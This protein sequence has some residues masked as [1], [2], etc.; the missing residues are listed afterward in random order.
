M[1]HRSNERLGRAGEELEQ[2]PTGGGA[3]EE[4]KA[5][6]AAGYEVNRLQ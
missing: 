4:G 2:V 6:E 5:G 1:I 3:R